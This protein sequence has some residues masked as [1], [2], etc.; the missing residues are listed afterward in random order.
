MSKSKL[1]CEENSYIYYKLE[2]LKRALQKQN[3]D[4]KAS[5]AKRIQ[6]ALEKFPLPII[7]GKAAALLVQGVGPWWA[8]EIDSWLKDKPVKRKASPQPGNKKISYNPPFRSPEW[9]CLMCLNKSEESLATYDFPYIISKYLSDYK[10]EEPQNLDIILQHLAEIDIIK[11]ENGKYFLTEIGKSLALKLHSECPT[12]QKPLL[13]SFIP[14]SWIKNTSSQ[15]FYDQETDGGIDDFSIVLFVDS[16]ERQSMDFNVICS[17]LENRNVIVERRKLWIG[18]YQWV[19]RVKIGKKYQ[20][21]MLNYVV[22]RKT[23]DDLAQSIIDS[24]YEDQKIRMKMSNA[25][26][27]Y[28]LEGTIVKKSSKVNS[29]TILNSLLST[30]FN[31]NFLIKNTAD[32]KDTLNWLAR[33]TNALFNEVSSWSYS[34]ISSLSTYEEFYDFTSPHNGVTV[35]DIFGKQLRAIE[36]LGE[37]STLAILKK[38]KT[39]MK[40]FLELKNA[41]DKGKRELNRVLK[42]IKLANGNCISKNTRNAL[43]ELFLN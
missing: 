40:M 30:K 34:K 8:S 3:N 9:V 43:I 14:D 17:R 25:V 20:D 4:Q 39:P 2:S 36:N 41:Q 33:F 32:S 12:V 26:C 10:L 28:L 31:Y 22:E 21:Y 27:I 16:A 6:Q 37:Q 5:N 23:A 42:S 24:R 1:G 38:Y 35:G 15:E 7:S 11:E 29:S 13:E 19:C 18:D